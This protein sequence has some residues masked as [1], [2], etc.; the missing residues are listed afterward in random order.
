MSDDCVFCKIIAGELPARV[1]H[2]DDSVVVFKDIAPKAPVHLLVVP[3]THLA[4]LEDGGC[5]RE[6]LLGHMVATACTAAAAEGVTESGYRLVLNN[7]PDS[8]QEVPHI[9]LHVLGGRRLG[10]MG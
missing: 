3:R 7:G 5:D 10:P 9:H 8:G 2:S 4:D 6:D 1:I